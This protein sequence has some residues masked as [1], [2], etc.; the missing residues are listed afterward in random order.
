MKNSPLEGLF[1]LANICA[2]QLNINLY[3]LK[4]ALWVNKFS[5]VEYFAPETGNIL[6]KK[7][8]ALGGTF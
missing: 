4:R 7:S 5:I 2:N 8:P 3:A 6:Q 1:L